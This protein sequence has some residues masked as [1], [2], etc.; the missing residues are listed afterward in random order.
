MTITDYW[1][2]YYDK[3]LQLQQALSNY[4]QK[5]KQI[6]LPNSKINTFMSHNSNYS[7][8]LDWL[9]VCVLMKA[10]NGPYYTQILRV[11]KEYGPRR[12]YKAWF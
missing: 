4:P 2:D 5:G 8:E 12:L 10:N 1:L 9:P 6:L 7:V 3:D 11:N